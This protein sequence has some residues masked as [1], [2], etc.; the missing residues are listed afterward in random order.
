HPPPPRPRPPPAHRH[1]PVRHRCLLRR[2]VLLPRVLLHTVQAPGRLLPHGVPPPGPSLGDRPREG[3]VGVHPIVF[4]PPVRRGRPIAIAEKA[5][6][7]NGCYD[8]SA[9]VTPI[10]PQPDGGT[11]IHRPSHAASHV[12][13][14]HT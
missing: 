8:A 7:A 14:Q 2:R 4:R 5:A 6:P 12:T 1:Q 10:H 9:L 3:P 13:H 11:M